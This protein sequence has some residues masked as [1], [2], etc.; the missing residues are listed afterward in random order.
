MTCEA[1]S[2]PTSPG[3]PPAKQQTLPGEGW[4]GPH[5]GPDTEL[6]SEAGNLGRDTGQEA[7]PDTTFPHFYYSTDGYGDTRMDNSQVSINKR[8]GDSR[9][10][11]PAQPHIN[12]ETAEPEWRR[13][14]RPHC[15]GEGTDTNTAG[16]QTRARGPSPALSHTPLS[17]RSA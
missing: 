16:T 15:P 3:A 8:N 9:G 1:A 4:P 2:G 10:P 12:N 5:T 7:P 17:L 14:S 13:G 11:V 6:C